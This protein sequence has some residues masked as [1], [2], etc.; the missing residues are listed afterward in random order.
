MIFLRHCGLIAGVWVMASTV[1]GTYGERAMTHSASHEQRRH[2]PQTVVKAARPSCSV[3]SRDSGSC[4][5]ERA[6]FIE[7]RGNCWSLRA[8][9]AR[10]NTVSVTAATDA[11]ACI[12]SGCQAEGE[13]RAQLRSQTARNGAL[14]EMRRREPREPM[15]LLPVC[16]CAAF[17]P[18]PSLGEYRRLRMG[19]ADSAAADAAHLATRCNRSY[20]RCARRGASG[21][22]RVRRP[23][24]FARNI[25]WGLA[26][27]HPSN[28]PCGT[29]LVCTF[30]QRLNFASI[31]Q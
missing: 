9:A 7:R 2:P 24:G 31:A 16:L 11:R 27:G 23:R 1:R 15:K 19:R 5:A 29:A 22:P 8:V 25:S 13:Q 28:A 30:H 10:A 17:S 18:P 14:A 26:A 3:G 4:G 6:L 12:S 20:A 21:A